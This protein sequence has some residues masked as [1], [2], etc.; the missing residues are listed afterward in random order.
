M[1]NKLLRKKISCLLVIIA[2]FSTFFFSIANANAQTLG[3]AHRDFVNSTNSNVDGHTASSQWRVHDRANTGNFAEDLKQKWQNLCD[4]FNFKPRDNS[5]STNNMKPVDAVKPFIQN[6]IKDEI[7]NTNL[8]DIT[9]AIKNF[10]RNSDSLKD[11]RKN[12]SHGNEINYNNLVD[13][14]NK[15][16]NTTE[17]IATFTNSEHTHSFMRWTHYTLK[18][19][20]LGTSNIKQASAADAAVSNML[21]LMGNDVFTNYMNT[22]TNKPLDLLDGITEYSDNIAYKMM[23]NTFTPQD[24]VGPDKDGSHGALTRPLPT[25]NEQNNKFLRE[26]NIIKKLPQ[27]IFDYFTKNFIKDL[28]KL[29]NKSWDSLWKKFSDLFKADTKKKTGPGDARTLPVLETAIK[30]NIYL[31]PIEEEEI[32]VRFK[33]PELLETVIPEYKDFWHATAKPNGNLLIDG[34]KYGY[35]FYE[36]DTS[37]L[38]MQ[39]EE[40][41][42]IK[43]ETKKEQLTEIATKYKFNEQETKDFVTFWCT[44]LE[45][46]VSY[47]MYPQHTAT[48]DAL[49]PMEIT[50]IPNTIF[51][52][53][54]LFAPVSSDLGTFK[55]P[56]ISPIERSGFTVTEWGGIVMD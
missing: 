30:P 55:D 51:R 9:D 1:K 11:A 43:P 2:S 33:N 44:K 41:W 22:H 15:Y 34:K 20:G 50:P 24:I 21:E 40:G 18:G 46:N 37:T 36:S 19:M 47:V 7:K 29:V 5:T 28:S 10:G 32:I 31:Y 39:K 49:M 8:N 6:K 16:I 25:I 35:L 3:S 27:D 23:S 26:L 42:I 4:S 52:V 12:I 56:I 14:A 13:K 53:W 38:H 54:F 48:I 17:N 45:N